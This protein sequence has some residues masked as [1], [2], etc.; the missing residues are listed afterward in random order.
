[1]D[2]LL[3]DL[4]SKLEHKLLTS[5][6]PSFFASRQQS[7][8][9]KEAFAMLD[10]YAAHEVAKRSVGI[11]RRLLVHLET[12]SGYFQQLIETCDGVA[13][14]PEM[15]TGL[16]EQLGHCF[17]LLLRTVNRILS[18]HGFKKAS[19]LPMLEDA[20]K[21]LAVR[22]NSEAKEAEIPEKIEYAF[23]YIENFAGS[24]PNFSCAIEHVQL[25]TTLYNMHPI[26]NPESELQEKYSQSLPYSLS[27]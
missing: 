10:L 21:F 9:P 24:L 17:Y 13:D 8:S 16:A 26:K 12:V 2:L 5:S 6:K 20:L 7:G 14:G 3:S 18:W 22:T 4:A 15:F 25:M 1:M 19:N 23:N 11:I 27:S